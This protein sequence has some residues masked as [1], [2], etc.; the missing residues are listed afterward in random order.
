MADAGVWNIPN[1]D[2]ARTVHVNIGSAQGPLV[3]YRIHDDGPNTVF[4]GNPAL[5][6]MGGAAIPP[7]SHADISGSPITIG[8]AAHRGQPATESASGTYELIC[9]QPDTSGVTTRATNHPLRP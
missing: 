4:A 7:G 8:I 1:V 9:C 2:T 5:G 3:V 6:N